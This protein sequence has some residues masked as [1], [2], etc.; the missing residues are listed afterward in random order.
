MGGASF[1]IPSIRLGRSFRVRRKSARE[2]KRLFAARELSIGPVVAYGHPKTATRSIERAIGSLDGAEVFH[3]HMLDPVHFT[4][5]NNIFV[6][7]TKAG[8]CPE[9]Q[10]A[11]WPLAE[12]LRTGDRI[13]L[14]T[15]VRDPVAVN[16][17]WFFFGLQRW[18]R[19][20]SPVDPASIP[21][22]TLEE[23]FHEVFP[24]EGV[25]H[26]FSEEW[27]RVTGVSM[28]ALAPVQKEGSVTVPFASQ[29]RACVLSAHLPD[30]RKAAVLESFLAV[31][32]GSISF[33]RVNR[34]ND[35]PSPEIYERL[36]KLVASDH[37]YLERMYASEY[38]RC[39]FG[40]TQ[41]SAFQ[42]SWKALGSHKRA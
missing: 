9:D 15:A 18:L 37:A 5:K 17:S 41:L 2:R 27:T 24:H 28:D 19:S 13:T 31:Q 20:P 12:A 21:F 32:P 26:W 38:A 42:A 36:K 39:F 23:V 25:L 22:A 11:Q 4:R 30:T 7:P 29:G 35:R 3:A 16:V 33:P 8:L 34:G 6:P 40:R 10:P 14:V 1:N